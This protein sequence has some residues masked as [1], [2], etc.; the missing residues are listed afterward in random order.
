MMDKPEAKT[1]RKCGGLMR[2]GVATGQTY[3]S[4]V[5]DDLGGDVRTIYA[6]GPGRIIDCAKCADCGWS[7]TS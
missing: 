1:C 6:G 2:S 3:T 5:P 4:G 7:V